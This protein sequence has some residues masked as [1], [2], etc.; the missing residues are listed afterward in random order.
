MP[1]FTS[2]PIPPVSCSQERAEVGSRKL[3]LYFFSSAV[4]TQADASKP[5]SLTSAHAAQ[6]TELVSLTSHR[7]SAPCF[8]PRIHLHLKLLPQEHWPFLGF[9][10]ADKDK[11]CERERQRSREVERSR[12][13]L[14]LLTPHEAAALLLALRVPMDSTA[15]QAARSARTALTPRA[16]RHPIFPAS[17]PPS[18]SSGHSPR[19]LTLAW[20]PNRLGADGTVATISTSISHAA[21]LA[22]STSRKTP[23]T[24]S[25]T[26][27]S[28]NSNSGKGSGGG[29]PNLG[30][31][32]PDRRT[33]D[34]WL[35]G[36]KLP[37]W[38][39]ED[40]ER[41]AAANT[42]SGHAPSS[43]HPHITHRG[44]KRRSSKNIARSQSQAPAEA[45]NAGGGGGGGGMPDVGPWTATFF[46]AFY[47]QMWC[48]YCA[49]LGPI[50]DLP[51]SASLRCASLGNGSSTLSLNTSM[52]GSGSGSM[53]ASTVVPTSPAS[54]TMRHSPSQ[55]DSSYSSGA[56]RA[57][58]GAS[59]KHQRQQ[60][61]EQHQEKVVAPP[62]AARPRPDEGVD[63]GFGVGVYVEDG[64]EFV[65]ESFGEGWGEQGGSRVCGWADDAALLVVVV[66][67]FTHR[68]LATRRSSSFPQRKPHFLQNDIILSFPPR[69][70][71]THARMLACI[72][73]RH[74]RRHLQGLAE[75]QAPISIPPPAH[76]PFFIAVC[77]ES[78]GRNR[79]QPVLHPTPPASFPP[80]KPSTHAAHARPLSWF[81]DAQASYGACGQGCGERC[82][83]V[84]W[85]E[86][87]GGG[88]EVY[89]PHNKYNQ[90][91]GV[92]PLP[93][94]S[95]H[96]LCN[97]GSMIQD[98]DMS[99][100]QVLGGSIARSWRSYQ[101]LP[102]G[103]F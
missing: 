76:S 4:S 48:T 26:H 57:A 72:R 79:G 66:L 45:L 31:A 92:P 84:V 14:R 29:K 98:V 58:E 38:G 3:L 56:G 19:D 81:F 17:T 64:A 95:N 100:I 102:E 20:T 62:A 54:S 39:K 99:L 67:A 71:G 23:T 93:L 46:A 73:L 44:H 69:P 94:L 32:A 77:V 103:L 18:S 60:H 75:L 101:G 83:N 27:S 10:C 2:A 91:M 43:H 1:Q 13:V 24:P 61:P 40:Q 16:R 37:G 36:V 33:E 7:R 68:A 25:S 51:T 82:G 8:A 28:S 55:S 49:G 53:A 90:G 65:G 34:I 41:V 11:E 70:S 87:G 63:V 6:P 15:A 50:R 96:W 22:S 42:A 78:P 35:M 85:A 74:R 89:F 97:V 9:G 12:R 47:A 30:D 86:R 88:V 21:S 5:S 80:L 59:R 52:T